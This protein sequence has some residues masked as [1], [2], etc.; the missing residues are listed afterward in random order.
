MIAPTFEPGLFIC[1]REF[2]VSRFADCR[3]R[4]FRRESEHPFGKT[5][6]STQNQ[7][8]ITDHK[9]PIP[10]A[11]L[12]IEAMA[13]FYFQSMSAYE[14]HCN[15]PHTSAEI[16]RDLENIWNA[17]QL[18]LEDLQDRRRMSELLETQLSKCVSQKR[19]FI[20]PK[21]TARGRRRK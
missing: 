16:Y 2:C 18:T 6:S 17:A 20:R 15:Q 19:C 7:G 13:L 12:P 9:T 21:T 5:P 8:M 10:F 11:Q 1:S 3:E 14:Y 4:F